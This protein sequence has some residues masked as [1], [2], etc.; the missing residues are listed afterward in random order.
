VTTFETIAV[1][2][3]GLTVSRIVWRRFRRYM[4]GLVA[5]VL[6]INPGLAGAGP[7]LPYGTKFTMPIEPPPQTIIRPVVNIWD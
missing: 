7:I 3:E 2:A 5:R 6:D 1:K 4:P